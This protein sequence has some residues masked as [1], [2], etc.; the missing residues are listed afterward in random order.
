MKPILLAFGLLAA[1]SAHAGSSIGVVGKLGQTGTKVWF[2]SL[3]ASKDQPSCAFANPGRFAIDVSTREGEAFDGK[4]RYAAA[5]GKTVTFE[6]TG[7]CSVDPAV[8][9]LKSIEVDQ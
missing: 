2:Q 3:G 5:L 6:G 8:E 9:T 1:A 7:V 4:L